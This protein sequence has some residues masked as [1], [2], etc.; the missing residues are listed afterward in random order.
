MIRIFHLVQGLFPFFHFHTYITRKMCAAIVFISPISF[1][2]PSWLLLL[3]FNKRKLV[4]V[5]AVS[6]YTRCLCCLFIRSR[7]TKMLNILKITTITTW[8]VHKSNQKN[9]KTWTF[10]R[11]WRLKT[12]LNWMKLHLQRAENLSIQRSTN[13]LNWRLNFRKTLKSWARS[14]LK[15]WVVWKWTS[16]LYWYRYRR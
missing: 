7:G 3:I 9:M 16:K 2:A 11:D 14:G 12:E 10:G 1:C 15:F 6:N 4:V 13:I 8:N 5:F